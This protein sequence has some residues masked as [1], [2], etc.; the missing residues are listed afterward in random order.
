MRRRIVASQCVTH[1]RIR[2]SVDI[3]DVFKLRA[4]YSTWA[5]CCCKSVAKVLD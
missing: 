2:Y 3:V 4:T 5:V 1:T